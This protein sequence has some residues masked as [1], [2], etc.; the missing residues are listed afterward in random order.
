MKRREFIFLAGLIG[1]AA[2]S[3]DGQRVARS[4]PKYYRV[5]FR[6]T[7][8]LCRTYGFAISTRYA[9]GCANVDM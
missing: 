4:S 6:L 2:M 3:T 9:K 1:G 5:G 8:A 7:G